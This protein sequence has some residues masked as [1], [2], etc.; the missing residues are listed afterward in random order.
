M[1]T[2]G[3]YYIL[4]YYRIRRTGCVKWFHVEV[5]INWLVGNHLGQHQISGNL[6]PEFTE[7]PIRYLFGLYKILLSYL[8]VIYIFY[9]QLKRKFLR[10][11]NC[12]MILAHNLSFTSD[13]LWLKHALF[14]KLQSLCCSIYF[15]DIIIIEVACF[16]ISMYV[17]FVFQDV[18]FSAFTGLV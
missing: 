8:M 5:V 1:R 3:I 2:I 12:Q 14:W 13:F 9:Q 17:I 16:H 10:C 15:E 4:F 11:F 6:T 18:R 7:R